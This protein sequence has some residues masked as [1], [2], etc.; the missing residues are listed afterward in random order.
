MSCQPKSRSFQDSVNLEDYLYMVEAI[1]NKFNYERVRSIRD[2]EIYGYLS[3]E[4][5]VCYSRFDPSKA[6]FD[7]YLSSH[8]FN[9]AID[10][11]RRSKR[12]KRFHN[13][14][15]VDKENLD[16]LPAH[17]AESFFTI[18]VLPSLL[19]ECPR[20]TPRD[21][22][23]RHILMEHYLTERSVLE[24]SKKYSSTRTTIYNRIKKSLAKIR[25]NHGISIELGGEAMH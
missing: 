25:E 16:T 18:D 21:I 3:Q 22:Q 2:S 19:K 1:S 10:F 24:L 17:S 6:S 5:V 13:H 7:K 15:L 9:R 23:D 20:D 12:K 11:V 8:L 4:L 14:L